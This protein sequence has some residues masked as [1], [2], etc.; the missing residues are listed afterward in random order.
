MPKQG[1]VH[2]VYAKEANAWRVEV[3]SN[4]R[5]SGTH[6]GKPA[7]VEQGRRLAR[8]GTSPNS[9]CT[10]KTA[11]SGIAA[12]TATTHSRHAARR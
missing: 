3:T 5:A 12:A 9:W 7:A 10:S 8:N 4:K 2:V 1:D 11:R 6:P